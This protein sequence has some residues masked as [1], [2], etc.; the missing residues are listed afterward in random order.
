MGDSFYSANVKELI[1]EA[2]GFLGLNPGIFER[3][4]SPVHI[5]SV[6]WAKIED[7]LPIFAQL[8][9]DFIPED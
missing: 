1:E 6:L 2:E 3:F 8:Q 5:K 4:Y 9:P 7:I